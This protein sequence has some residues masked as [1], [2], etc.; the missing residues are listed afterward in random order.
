MY[1]YD[2]SGAMWLFVGT[3]MKRIFY[4]V[5]AAMSV[6]SCSNVYEIQADICKEYRAK[7]DTA[8]S[9]KSLKEVN[10]AF[11]QEIVA[12]LKKNQ[13][14]VVQAAK[15]ARQYRDSEQ[16][17]A[18][19]ESDYVMAY[20]NKFV[21]MVL[22]EQCDLYVDYIGKLGDAVTYD[23]LSALNRS[24]GSAVSEVASKC[25]VE[26]KTVMSKNIFKEQRAAL[27]KAEGD[28]MAAY[29]TRVAPLLYAKEKSIYEKYISKVEDVVGY[30]RIKEV[31]LFCKNEIAIFQN[32]NA[33][34]MQRMRPE[35]YAAE[36][37]D[38][39]S[40]KE[41]FEL[42]YMKKAS[43]AV[44]EYR[45][46]LYTGAVEI[47]EAVT[48]ANE[49][50]KVNRAFLDVNNIFTKENSAEIMWAENAAAAGDKYYKRE[51]DNAKDLF[52][53]VLEASDKKAEELGLR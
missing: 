19:A 3:N 49:L 22:K 23:E 7:V 8:S 46:E 29:S 16:L 18:K 45:K 50:D 52:D 14:K 24:V 13:E 37:S 44:L 40:A 30:E 20:L 4:V 21:P 35:D 28:Y 10:D 43:Q 27:E 9:Y 6:A 5:L 17:L 26:M 36:K 12:F 42:C 39:A 11:E 2:I 51:V 31:G 38:A 33:A 41:R 25:A 53:M 15:D 34:V 48:D 47:L 1:R 32:D